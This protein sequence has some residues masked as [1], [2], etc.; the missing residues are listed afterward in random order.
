MITDPLGLERCA[1]CGN[2]FYYDK[3]SEASAI[4]QLSGHHGFV[5]RWCAEDWLNHN[6]PGGNV[7]NSELM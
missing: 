7:A 6:E 3:D 2:A 5:C 1:V 4:W